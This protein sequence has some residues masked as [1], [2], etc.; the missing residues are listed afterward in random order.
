MHHLFQTTDTMYAFCLPSE[1]SLRISCGSF[2]TRTEFYG[3]FRINDGIAT[4]YD[5][6][7]EGSEFESQ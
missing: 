4:G 3:L 7:T 2:E 5:W 6:T 1:C